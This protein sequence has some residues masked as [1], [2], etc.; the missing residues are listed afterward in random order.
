MKHNI[1]FVVLT[2]L[3]LALGFYG[4]NIIGH[5][6]HDEAENQAIITRD[7]TNTNAV[8]IKDEIKKF[9]PMSLVVKNAQYFSSTT[10]AESYA[11]SA[12]MIT[13]MA[14]QNEKTIISQPAGQE[15]D[16]AMKFD[17]TG[18]IYVEKWQYLN[19]DKQTRMLDCIIWANDLSIAYIRFYNSDNY[20]LSSA[21][22][23]NGLDKLNRYSEEFYPYLSDQY[24]TIMNYKDSL[25]IDNGSND[26]LSENDSDYHTL[27]RE[28]NDKVRA[29]RLGDTSSLIKYVESKYQVYKQVVQD[30]C[31]LPDNPL[32]SFWLSQLAFQDIINNQSYA[33]VGGNN[34]TNLFVN[35]YG[36]WV[37]PSY[38]A[39][40]GIIYQTII[41]G[42]HEV[43]IIYNVREDMIEGYYFPDS[44]VVPLYVY[45]D[46]TAYG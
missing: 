19:P 36:V 5:F 42:T 27:I 41:A 11:I 23:N 1:I 29:E 45:Y 18:Y 4:P 44:S 7:R 31:S 22:M 30:N 35:L 34:V 3:V 16:K 43:T 21:E 8:Y 15:L 10:N 24:Y 33:T 13:A 12:A 20:Q 39:K 14:S 17:K 46:E 2:A 25:F 32:P 9:N 40:D 26:K 28:L 38:S 6:I 37:K